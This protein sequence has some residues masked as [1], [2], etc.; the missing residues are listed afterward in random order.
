MLFD[1]REQLGQSQRCQIHIRRREVGVLDAAKVRVRQP[2]ISR[3]GMYEPLP[4]QCAQGDD[5]VH[6]RQSGAEKNDSAARGRQAG[7]PCLPGIADPRRVIGK[8]RLP[9]NPAGG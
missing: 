4:A 8:F 7:F 2:A 1:E 6:C 3:D 9:G 5:A